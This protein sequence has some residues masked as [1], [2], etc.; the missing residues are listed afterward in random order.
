MLTPEGFSSWLKNKVKS[1]FYNRKQLLDFLYN[2]LKKPLLTSD[3]F[4]QTP[5]IIKSNKSHVKLQKI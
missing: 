2:N 4:G 5:D 3:I 1:F